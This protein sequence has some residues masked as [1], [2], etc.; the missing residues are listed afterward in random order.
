MLE[1]IPLAFRGVPPANILNY[2]DISSSN[3]F[4]SKWDC[5][6]I[7]VLVV[8]RA[9]KKDRESAVLLGAVNI[10][11][12]NDSIAHLGCNAVLNGDVRLVSGLSDTCGQQHAGSYHQECDLFSVHGRPYEEE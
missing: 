11:K 4:I 3:C 12:E 10:C 5:A 8:R 9:L 1:R 7:I 6:P 2:D